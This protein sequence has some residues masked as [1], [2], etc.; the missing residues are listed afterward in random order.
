M[1]QKLLLTCLMCGGAALSAWA[2][3]TCVIE[4]TFTNDR[5][6]HTDKAIDKVYLNR[7]DEM[8]NL[9]PVDSA[10]VSDGKF[11]LNATRCLGACGLAPVMM[12]DDD[13]YGRLT[14]ADIPGIL[15]KYR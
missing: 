1:L 11:T 15:A 12:I 7:M 3:Q 14:P 10:L 9:I 4:G 2:Q 6:R 13:V 8:E 5:L